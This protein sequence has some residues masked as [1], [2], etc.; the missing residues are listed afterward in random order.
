MEKSEFVRLMLTKLP[1]L[2]LEWSHEVQERWWSSF[3]RL[4]ELSDYYPKPPPDPTPGEYEQG[5][6]PAP[7]TNAELAQMAAV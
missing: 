4:W 2:D 7:L 5:T 6:V 3:N 1:Q